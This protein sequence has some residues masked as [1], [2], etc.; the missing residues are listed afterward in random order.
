M[1][2]QSSVASGLVLA[3]LAAALAGC[4]GMR[5]LSE[6]PPPGFSLAGNWKLDPLQST[7]SRKALRELVP[8][9]RKSHRTSTSAAEAGEGSEA[10][11]Q[12]PV[13]SGRSTGYGGAGFGPELNFPP[14]ISLQQSLLA[15]GDYL[16]IEQRPNELVVAN[17]ETTRS[18]VPGEKSVISVPSGVADQK[19]GWKGKQYWIE[20]HPQVGPRVTEKLLLSDKGDQLIETIDVSSEGRVRPLHVK[21]VY[22]PTREIPFSVP[23]EN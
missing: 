16:R 7:D 2:S 1:A 13:R 22:S 19:S 14:D 6:A 21:R 18:F 20:I 5:R 4:V 23:V 9:N 8:P 17:G 15:G 11:E 12:G 10:E 3:C